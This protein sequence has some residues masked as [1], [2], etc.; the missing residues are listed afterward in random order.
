MTDRHVVVKVALGN[1][2]QSGQL[3]VATVAG[4]QVYKGRSPYFDGARALVDDHGHQ[5]SDYV[6]HIRPDGTRSQPVAL[7]SLYWI[8]VTE[9]DRGGLRR[10]AWR[11]VTQDAVSWVNGVRQDARSGSKATNVGSDTE[12]RA[13][14]A[15]VGDGR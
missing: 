8:E 12:T 2:T 10:R 13:G 3:Y 1:L 9:S 5:L 7:N 11:G 4:R 15:V 14:G 6:S